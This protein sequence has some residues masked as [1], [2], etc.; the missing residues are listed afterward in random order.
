MQLF[1]KIVDN[2]ALTQGVLYFLKKRISKTTAVA[3][4]EEA[5]VVKWGTPVAIDALKAAAV[6]QATG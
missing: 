5:A 3:G 1:L 4:P 6:A 2:P